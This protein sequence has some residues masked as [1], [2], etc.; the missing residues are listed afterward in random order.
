MR[1]LRTCLGLLAAFSGL[2]F[3]SAQTSLS[4]S[5]TTS[6]VS[7]TTTTRSGGQ[8]TQI[9]TAVPT[10]FNVTYTYTSTPTSTSSEAASETATP[11]PTPEPIVLDTKL[12]P[13]FGVLGALLILTG[14]PSAF[15]GHKNR[16]YAVL[17]LHRVPPADIIFKDLFLP[18]WFLHTFSG[19]HRA[20]SEIRGPTC[21]QPSQQDS[22][23]NVRLS[24][25][26]CR[27]CR[28]RHRYFL[29][30]SF[31]VLYRCMGRYAFN[32]LLDAVRFLI[33]HRFCFR[34]V[35]TVLSQWRHN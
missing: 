13:A 24:L 18:H 19:V 8:S 23:R 20:Y 12:D 6:T 22:P 7:V 21:C 14:L 28:R 31:S 32:T 27:Y 17:F 1:Y 10:T 3:V 34:P 15:W 35:D 9:I 25:G 30:E 11:T 33:A 4:L 2:G 16:W 29:L 26:N 5:L